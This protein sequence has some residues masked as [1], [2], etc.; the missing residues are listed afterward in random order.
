[1]CSEESLRCTPI[2]LVHQK[3]QTKSHPS[4]SNDQCDSDRHFESKNVQTEKSSNGSRQ[5]GGSRDGLDDRDTEMIDVEKEKPTMKTKVYSGLL[6]VEGLR[7]VKE[8]RPV[9]Y[10][11]TYEGLWNQCQETSCI[12]VDLIFNY[13]KVISNEFLQSHNFKLLHFPPAIPDHL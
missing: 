4:H 13:L 8:Q 7:N 6:F 12:S 5:P 1:M 3:V 2:K 10:F 9:E 11:I